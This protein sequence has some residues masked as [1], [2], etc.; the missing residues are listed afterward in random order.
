MYGG[1][2]VANAYLIWVLC[3]LLYKLTHLSLTA[4]TNHIVHGLKSSMFIRELCIFIQY[5]K[6]LMYCEIRDR[7]AS[8]TL[9]TALTCRFVCLARIFSHA[10]S[11]AHNTSISHDFYSNEEMWRRPHFK[12]IFWKWNIQ[13]SILHIGRHLKSIFWPWNIQSTTQHIGTISNLS[14]VNEI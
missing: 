7:F 10:C 11:C 13:P 8:S 6:V 14:F 9:P 1:E 3:C 4:A 5:S 12:F 2:S